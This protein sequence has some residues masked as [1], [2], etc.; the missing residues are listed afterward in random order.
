MKKRQ[1]IIIIGGNAAGAAAAAKAKRTEPLADVWLLE[2]SEFISTGTCEL[3][4]VISGEITDY[5]KLVFFTPEKFQD[6][7][8]VNVRVAHS[9]DFVD[10]KKKTIEVTDVYSGKTHQVSY[11]K[12]IFATGSQVNP[13][14]G[15]TGEYDNLFKLKSVA[16]LKLISDYFSSN[17]IKDA[18]ILGAGYVGLELAESLLSR[19]IKVRL[20]EKAPYP[21]PTAEPEIRGILSK[22]IEKGGID[23]IPNVQKYSFRMAE[24][25]ISAIVEGS[26]V[27]ES[28]VFFNCTGFVPNVSAAQASGLKIGAAGGIS[29]NYYLQTSDPDIFAAGDCSESVEFI[30][31]NKMISNLATIAHEQGHLAGN[32]AVSINKNI[33]AKII[34]NTSVRLFGS[35]LAQCGLSEEDAEKNGFKVNTVT[36]ILP[37]L[38]PIMPDSGNTFIKLNYDKSSKRVLGASI[39]GGKEVSGYADIIQLFIRLKIPATELSGNYYN[40]TP[41]L[42]PFRNILSAIGR[43]IK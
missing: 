27:L 18:V 37:N 7:K 26:R 9:V 29:V 12:L 22:V 11:D 20:I 13:L 38:V 24:N 1:V 4:Y 28:D 19:G 5:Q 31:G 3:P 34:L 2:K 39:W 16:D 17:V 6:E 36:E 32:N 21:F 43:K 30:T 15:L 25:K 8:K 14:N 41:T 35:Y 23:F 33:T 10:R 40:Y 42:S